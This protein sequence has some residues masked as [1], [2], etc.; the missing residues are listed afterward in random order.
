M[1]LSIPMGAVQVHPTPLIG[2][3]MAQDQEIW[4]LS[5]QLLL[6]AIPVS[7][8]SEIENVGKII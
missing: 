3:W 5:G 4:L 7:T 2:A 1:P 6:Q 8:I